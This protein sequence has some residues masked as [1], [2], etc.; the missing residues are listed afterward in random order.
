MGQ[1]TVCESTPNYALSSQLYPG[2]IPP[3][4]TSVCETSPGNMLPMLPFPTVGAGLGYPMPYPFGVGLGF[5][6]GQPGSTVCET[7]SNGH[8]PLGYA[9]VG[10]PGLSGFAGL[11]SI[12]M[13]ALSNLGV[14]AVSSVC[15]TIPNIAS[16]ALPVGGSTTVCENVPNFMSYGLPY[17]YGFP[18]GIN[19]VGGATT[20]C[21]PTVHG[22]GVGLPFGRSFL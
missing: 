14:P 17:G 22:Y 16:R 20:V 5:T 18:I 2:L 3:S 1:T 10:F 15:E 12:P 4:T 8:T 19:P 6:M 13:P 21:E 9:G 7:V 11:P